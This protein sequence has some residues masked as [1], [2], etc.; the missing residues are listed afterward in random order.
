MTDGTLELLAKAVV[1][2]V[3]ISNL[4]FGSD[5]VEVVNSFEFDVQLNREVFKYD[6]LTL[7]MG[8][9]GTNNTKTICKIL[10][11]RT[12]DPSS[13]WSSCNTQQMTQM[14]IQPMADL[15][16]GQTF[17]ISLPRVYNAGEM[18]DGIK[19]KWDDSSNTIMVDQTALQATNFTTLTTALKLKTLTV[20]KTN[21][22]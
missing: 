10:D 12:G 9:L 6:R 18:K 20:V 1:P 3:T 19:A 11:Q 7:N 14:I 21:E 22:Y 13:V 2:T 4:R 15:I 8:S 5:V 16:T 17:T